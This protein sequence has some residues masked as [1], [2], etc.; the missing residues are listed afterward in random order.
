MQ[1]HNL[2][3]LFPAKIR[4]NRDRRDVGILKD[5]PDTAIRNNAVSHASNEI[6]GKFV[7]VNLV[8]EGVLRP[9]ARKRKR[10]DTHNLGKVRVVHRLDNHRFRPSRGARIE[11]KLHRVPGIFAGAASP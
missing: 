8:V 1:E 2:A 6:V 4:M 9:R 10:F 7:F 5:H 11:V 3:V